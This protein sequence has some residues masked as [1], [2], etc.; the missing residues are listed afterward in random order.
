MRFLF[1]FL[2]FFTTKQVSSFPLKLPV[3]FCCLL[4]FPPFYMTWTHQARHTSYEAHAKRDD[5]TNDV[6][7]AD[8]S[9]NED[10]SNNSNASVWNIPFCCAPSNFYGKEAT[11]VTGVQP[12]SGSIGRF[13]LALKAQ[14]QFFLHVTTGPRYK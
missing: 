14:I 9:C 10:Y 12:I 6:D 1:L 8:A 4:P 3:P 5:S 11:P 13:V 7:H 2:P